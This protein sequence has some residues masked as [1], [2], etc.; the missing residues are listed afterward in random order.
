MFGIAEPKTLSRPRMDV[1]QWFKPSKP[2]Q[3]GARRG[4][5]VAIPA[6]QM[7][8]PGGVAHGL[9]QATRL[10]DTSADDPGVVIGLRA[11]RAN[12]FDDPDLLQPLMNVHCRAATCM[13]SW[14]I[15]RLRMVVPRG[16]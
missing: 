4:R 14:A 8:C 9:A 6:F 7:P 5:V 10:R 16:N 15:S 11:V 13:L 12:R 1:S 3:R 2:M